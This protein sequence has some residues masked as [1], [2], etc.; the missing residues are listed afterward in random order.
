[1]DHFTYK[2]GEYYVEDVAIASIA[3]QVAT[4]FYCYST[5]T[6]K[7]HIRRLQ[8]C[9]S[10]LDHRVCYAMKANYNLD[11]L[12]QVAACG[13]GVDVVSAGEI[14]FALAAGVLAENMVFSGV[15]KTADEMRYALEKNIFQFNIESGDELE[16][17][18]NVAESLNKKASIA[19]R[20]NPDVVARTHAK[21]STGHKTSKFGIPMQ[22][23][24]ATYRQAAQMPNIH[25]QGV[26]MHIGSQLT[27]LEP[28]DQALSR[29]VEY[30]ATLRAEGFDIQTVD[31]GGGLG[32]PY[33]NNETISLE[34]Y[35]ALVVKHTK[36]LNA[37]IVLE[38]GRMI[39]AN[40]GVLV[41]RV[42]RLKE[43]EGHHFVIVDAA[44]ND[45]L[46]PSLYDAY[47]EILP[48]QQP[49]DTQTKSTYD[50]VGPVCET[51]DIFRE[52]IEMST[53]KSGD[54]LVIRSAGAYG[55]AM[56][57]AYN[58]RPLVAEIVVDGDAYKV[59]RP[60]K[61]VTEMLADYQGK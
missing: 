59:S 14:E 58:L 37:T 60:A 10:E 29:L 4:P 11:L 36:P 39:A 51:G 22:Q 43:N 2:N 32:V 8:Q 12:K 49:A 30:V 25:V 44:M 16:V 20:V 27:D 57:S 45:L 54:L 48:N 21:I 35:A 5:N 1:M 40:A 19:V 47:H 38:P 53:I 7:H 34:D 6:F 13:A 24:L 18:Q 26:S 28:I 17:L 15:G 56:A 3:E 33:G 61:S 23:A 31:V 41:T 9:L 52:K 42:V 46:R 55:A 50:I